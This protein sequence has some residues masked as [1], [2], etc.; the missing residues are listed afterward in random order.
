MAVPHPESM[1]G[2]TH[3]NPSMKTEK[4]KWQKK[5]SK[6]FVGCTGFEP[7]TSC[8]SSKRSEPAELTPQ[9]Y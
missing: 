7:V 2:T 1:K 5:S 3:D 8:L 6:K 4:H 9:G